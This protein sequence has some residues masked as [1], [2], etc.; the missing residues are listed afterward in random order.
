MISLQ[1]TI[2]DSCGCDKR[3]CIDTSCDCLDSQVCM[4]GEHCNCNAK[5]KQ[6]QKLFGLS[7]WP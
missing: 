2:M 7:S 4:C 6:L 3:G 5:S 1:L